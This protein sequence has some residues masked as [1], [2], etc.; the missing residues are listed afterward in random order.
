MTAHDLDRIDFLRPARFTAVCG[1]GWRSLPMYS[2]GLAGSLWDVHVDRAPVAGGPMPSIVDLDLTA[3][4]AARELYA[5]V[6]P[7]IKAAARGATPDEAVGAIP[8]M[9][10]LAGVLGDRDG[11]LARAV[12]REWIRLLVEPTSRQRATVIV[13]LVELGERAREHL[14]RGL[15]AAPVPTTGDEPS[16][17]AT[18]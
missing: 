5:E 1:C 13:G 7:A 6:L 17:A 4:D 9:V 3:G 18:G 15:P 2:A 11:R 16:R 12:E 14:T 8:R 10:G